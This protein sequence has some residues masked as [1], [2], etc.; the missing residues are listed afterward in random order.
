[1]RANTDMSCYNRALA[2]YNPTEDGPM[3]EGNALLA[4]ARN[5]LQM[6]YL[7]SRWACVTD[8]GYVPHGM[9]KYGPAFVLPTRKEVDFALKFMR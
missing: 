5:E 6:L 1:M 9:G 4:L 3:K 2:M 8:V 7:F